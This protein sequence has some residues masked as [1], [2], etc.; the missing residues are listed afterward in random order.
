MT[1]MNNPPNLKIMTIGAYGFDVTTFFTALQQAHV[2]TFCDI[3][4]RRAVR[5]SEYAYA[6]SQR[7]Q[8][9][10]A[11]LGIRYLHRLDLAPTD[12]IRQQ[13]YAADKSKKVVKRQR[14]ELS[15]QFI[16]TYTAE[17]L[18]LFAPQ[19]LLDELPPDAK[20]L[21]LFCVEREP[22]ACLCHRSRSR[23][24]RSRAGRRAAS[25]CRAGWSRRT[26]G[27]R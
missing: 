7:L 5:G 3:R 9:R 16:T 25:G 13:Q 11:E 1:I 22:A 12:T 2:D 15:P 17:R 8:N 21:A 26:A 6:N 14:T 4:K 19:S 23:K 24:P 27:R 20:V 18:D 10:L